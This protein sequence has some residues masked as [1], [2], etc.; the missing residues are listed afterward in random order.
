MAEINVK[1]YLSTKSSGFRQLLY[2]KLTDLC[3][4]SDDDALKY[5]AVPPAVPV[6]SYASMLAWTEPDQVM[7]ALLANDNALLMAFNEW[8]DRPAT[9]TEPILEAVGNAANN[10]DPIKAPGS[11]LNEDAKNATGR[12]GKPNAPALSNTLSAVDSPQQ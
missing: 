8:L 12:K 2:S 4:T 10:I 3:S 7:L 1:P 11:A 6:W 9:E 5:F